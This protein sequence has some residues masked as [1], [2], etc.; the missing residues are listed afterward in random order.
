MIEKGKWFFRFGIGL[1]ILGAL[2]FM[3]WAMQSIGFY[4]WYVN[5]LLLNLGSVFL[6]LFFGL[7]LLSLC[8]WLLS[9]G[10]VLCVVGNWEAKK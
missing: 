3:A 9:I 5:E 4:N 1:L 6:S 2:C 10:L 8:V 7:G